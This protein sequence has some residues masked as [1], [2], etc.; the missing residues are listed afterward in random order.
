MR[1]LIFGFMLLGIF[2]CQK[3][4][5]KKE[6]SSE[7]SQILLFQTIN[8]NPECLI[9]EITNSDSENPLHWSIHPT[10]LKL[11]PDNENH[12]LVKAQ[13]IDSEKNIE[14]GFINLSTPERI[15]DYVIYDLKNP[16]S[17]GIYELKAKEVIP[18]VASDCFGSYELYYSKNAPQ[19]GLQ[20]LKEGL[21]LSNQKSVI[22]EDIAYILRD[23]NRLEEALEYFLISTKY[24]SSSEY[25][26]GEIEDIYRT[27]NNDVK[28]NEYKSKF[29][30]TQKS[31]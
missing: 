7:K 13:I 24:D 28:A 1:I 20:T 31:R 18:A 3:K 12:Y 6:S 15:A 23:E 14:T 26:L 21:N 25:I 5:N 9:Y 11:T 27:Q 10:D 30:K 29:E 8:Q 4:R 2:G 19:I 17:A 22:A 16:K